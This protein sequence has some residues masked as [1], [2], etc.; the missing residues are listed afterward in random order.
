MYSFSFYDKKEKVFIWLEIYMVKNLFTF[1]NLNNKYFSFA[2]EI[3]AF[4][5]IRDF[6]PEINQEALSCF[7]K[8]GWIAAPLAIWKNVSKNYAR[9]LC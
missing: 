1:L 6:K 9:H 4:Y 5:H 3:N 8:R 2:S 7:F